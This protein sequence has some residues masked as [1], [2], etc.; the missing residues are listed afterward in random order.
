MQKCFQ[1]FKS[2]IVLSWNYAISYQDQPRISLDAGERG[3]TGGGTTGIG[4]GDFGDGPWKDSEAVSWSRESE[5]IHFKN[6]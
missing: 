5:K 4:G 2:Q 1:E 3:L 6:S